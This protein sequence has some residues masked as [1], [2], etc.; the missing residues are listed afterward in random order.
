MTSDYFGIY[1]D[2]SK[3][4]DTKTSASTKTVPDT[5]SVADTFELVPGIYGARHI[6]RQS[7]TVPDTDFTC[8]TRCASLGYDLR[9]SW[10]RLPHLSVTTCASRRTDEVCGARHLWCQTLFRWQAFMVSDTFSLSRCQ[11]HL[12]TV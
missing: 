8:F 12:E 1:T 11:T 6:W 4:P 3:V 10:L 5:L 9:I 7:K 2:Y